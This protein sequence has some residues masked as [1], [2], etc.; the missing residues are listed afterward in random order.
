MTRTTRRFFE[1]RP[2]SVR[3]ADAA[4]TADRL[5]LGCAPIR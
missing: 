2:E 4:L 3:Q 5:L 1:T